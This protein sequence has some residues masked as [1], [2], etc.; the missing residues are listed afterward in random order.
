M[1]IIDTD[2][3]VVGAGPGGVAAALKLSYLN[4]PTVLV[5]KAT[6]PRDKVC[7][8]AI[9]GKVTMLLNR[10]DPKILERMELNAEALNP[11]WGI[12]FVSPNGDRFDLPFKMDYDEKQEKAPGYTMKRLHFDHFLVQEVNRRTNIQFLENTSIK[13]FQKTAH[14]YSI[15]DDKK[16]VEI[17][18]KLLIMANGAQST[19]SR[20]EGGLVKANKHHAGG[21][22]AYYK[23]I[24]PLHPKRFIELHYL[25]GITPGYFWIFPLTNNLSNVGLGLRTDIIKKRKINLNKAFNEAIE[26]HPLLS[27]RFKDA[28]L[29]GSV[30]GY[31]LPL[32]S[33]N[34]KISGDHYM[35]VGDA[36]YLIDPL[37]GEGIGNA[38]YSGF[39]A[40]E[41]AAKC[42][43]AKNFTSEYMIAYDHR[44][45]RVLGKE[46]KLSYQ[47][48]QILRSHSLANWLGKTISNNPK[49]IQ[50]MSS[51]YSDLDL[52]K[53]LVNPGFWLKY[54][55]R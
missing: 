17:N 45:K 26:Q 33:Q 28:E 6:F 9:S 11:V 21:L 15:S 5:D 39:I 7:G 48:Q 29:Q 42:L 46:M 24:N 34:R 18:T 53:K 20:K 54:L 13:N 12:E 51:M 31:G 27:Q 44:V 30:Q 14:G 55:F 8:D 38:F 3:C 41:Q 35:L 52:R 10:L 23:N 47:L 2:V 19:F 37:T 1:Q 16:N 50:L 32:G 49:L 25:E 43:E 36:G 4:I 40:A 22:R